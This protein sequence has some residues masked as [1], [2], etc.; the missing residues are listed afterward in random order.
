MEKFLIKKRE[1]AESTDTRTAPGL[2]STLRY[3]LILSSRF[4][5]DC[6]Y[7][8]YLKLGKKLHVATPKVLK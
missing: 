2:K 3:K 6:R 1:T 4:F 5:S 8:F 7:R